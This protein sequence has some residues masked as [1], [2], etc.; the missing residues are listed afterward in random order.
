MVKKIAIIFIILSALLPLTVLAQETPPENLEPQGEADV[1]PGE[2]FYRAQVLE[3]LKDEVQEIGEGSYRIQVL[4]VKIL[5]GDDKGKELEI[6]SEGVTSLN[7]GKG[8]SRGEQVVVYKTF[9]QGEPVYYLADTY[10]L[11]YLIYIV[12]AFFAIAILFARWKGVSSIIGLA[13][14]VLVIA[15]FIVPQIV[16]GKNP[17]IISLIAALI[18]ALVSIYLSHGFNKRT[19]IALAGTLITLGL[20]AALAYAFVSAARL[21][22][23]GSEEA[24]YLQF[25]ALEKLNLRGLLL[26]GI[27]LGALGVLDDVTTTQSATVD[28]LKKANPS[29]TS[30]DLYRGGISVGREHIASL[31]NTLF[32][33][34]AGASLPLFLFFTTTSSQPLWITL[35]AEFIAEEIIRTLVGSIALILAVPITTMLAAYFFGKSGPSKVQSGHFH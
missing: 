15:K 3:V 20:S 32:L 17:V 34:Y 6:N 21:F 26:G 30:A 24:F 12:I 29:F 2:F 25:G 27:I 31:V 23:V 35:N 11:P 9:V 22:G 28:E 14:S 33:A 13:I 8:V 16:A 18:I 4:K 1:V 7:G 10:R 19:S 5:S